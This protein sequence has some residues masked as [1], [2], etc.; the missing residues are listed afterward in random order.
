MRGNERSSVHFDG[1]AALSLRDRNPAQTVR[2]DR[3]YRGG[4]PTKG[5]GAR[6]K[7]DRHLGYH[8]QMHMVDDFNRLS[9]DKPTAIGCQLDMFVQPEVV[10][11]QLRSS[12]RAR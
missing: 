10:S 7:M 11:A 9:G 12:S 2:P 5:S 3:L 8:D 6:N 4:P 1:Q